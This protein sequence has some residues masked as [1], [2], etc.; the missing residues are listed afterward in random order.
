MEGKK[1]KK[2]QRLCKERR[3][4]AREFMHV[5]MHE[6]ARLVPKRELINKNQ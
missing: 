5:F 6:V 3:G 1:K 2:G 4:V